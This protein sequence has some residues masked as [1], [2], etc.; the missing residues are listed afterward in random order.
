MT[1]KHIEKWICKNT[2]T[3]TFTHSRILIFSSIFS[4]E[5]ELVETNRHLSQLK[6]NF[7]ASCTITLY[8][9]IC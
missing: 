7:N 4:L 9:F 1:K 8:Q 3:L 6:L 5:L 2:T